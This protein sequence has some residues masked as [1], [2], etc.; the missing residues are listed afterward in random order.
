MDVVWHVTSSL[1]VPDPDGGLLLDDGED[2]GTPRRLPLLYLMSSFGRGMTLFLRE[3]AQYLYTTGDHEKTTTASR[4]VRGRGVVVL[5][6][7]FHGSFRVQLHEKAWL[8]SRGDELQ[9]N[10]Y[11]LLYVRI[12]FNELAKMDD[13]AENFTLFLEHFF[14]DYKLGRFSVSDIYEETRM[15]VVARA[16]RGTR[17]DVVVLLVGEVA[18]LRSG[19]AGD[20]C[21]VLGFDIS[22]CVRSECC[23]LSDAGSGLGLTCCTTMESSLLLAERSASGRPAEP[24]DCITPGSPL[25][26][27]LRL[28]D[29]MRFSAGGDSGFNWQLSGAWRHGVRPEADL[30]AIAL[31]MMGG[32]VWRSA[33]LLAIELQRDVHGPVQDMLDRVERKLVVDSSGKDLGFTS[34]W[35]KENAA[36]RGQVVAASFLAKNVYEN[37][38]VV[39]VEDGDEPP[40]KKEDKADPPDPDQIDPTRKEVLVQRAQVASEVW[41][42]F[43]GPGLDGL[44]WGNAVSLGILSCGRALTFTPVMISLVLL[45]ALNEEVVSSPSS[46]WSA[47][48]ALAR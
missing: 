11:L 16:N 15:L 24:L 26:Q 42:Q 12:L 37:S 18:K 34:L 17:R 31:A 47:L 41:K 10:F 44:T 2:E 4:T 6:V 21:D 8:A 36:V 45:H 48:R 5:G 38:L 32:A 23:A 20:L 19:V 14:A 7:K 35:A 3:A 33:E 1:P 46:L 29:A 39:D 40:V 30:M 25:A 13:P 22:S 9:T 43:K 27:T 28:R